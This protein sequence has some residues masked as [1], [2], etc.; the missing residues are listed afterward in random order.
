MEQI[1]QQIRQQAAEQPR[2]VAVRSGDLALSYVELIADVDKVANRLIRNAVKRIGLY[3]DNGIDWIVTDLACAQAG[4]TVVP[5]PWFF[6]ESQL[7]H[8]MQSSNLQAVVGLEADRAKILPSG[9][10]VRLFGD[11]ALMLDDSVIQ[12]GE[13][14]S[15][16]TAK[17]SFTSGTTGA[18][19]GIPLGGALIEDV[20]QSIIALTR[21]LNIE[22]HLSLL[23]YSTLLENICGI[24]APLMTGKTVFAES[25][26]RLGLTSSLNIDAIRLAGVLTTTAAQ[27]L[28]VTPQLLKLLCMLVEKGLINPSDLLFVAVG[29]GHVGSALIERARNN[30]IP[31]F[32][33]YGLTEFAS[34]VSLNTPGQTRSGSVGKLLPHVLLE[35]AED[36]EIILRQKSLPATAVATGDLGSIDDDGFVFIDGRKKN[37]LVLSTGRNVSP[38][39]I[40]A[41]LHGEP[42]M[43]QCL[44]FGEGEANL[45]ALIVAD[46]NSKTESICQSVIEINRGLPAYARISTLHRLDTPFTVGNGLLT[47][48]GKPKRAEIIRRL[49]PLLAKAQTVSLTPFG[50]KFFNLDKKEPTLC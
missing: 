32:E 35:L 22:R 16:D 7:Q 34:V 6:S 39:W 3:L 37:T 13:G 8:V 12:A 25:A 15:S 23:P 31:V 45:H 49:N 1:L 46:S 28:I 38:E 44:V 9:R 33:G 4:I 21:N 5:L 48:T 19:K 42:M 43:T 26:N 14:V 11:T 24:Y 17:L 41:E 2:A 36:G 30:G 27:S 50:Q 20:C 29:G 10:S 18:P 47:E 40:E